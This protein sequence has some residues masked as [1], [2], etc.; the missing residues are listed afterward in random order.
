MKFESGMNS[1]K[2]ALSLVVMMTLPQKA[3]VEVCKKM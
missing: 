3:I 1:L 2:E